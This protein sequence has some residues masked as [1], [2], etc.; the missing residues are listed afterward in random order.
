MRSEEE[1][2]QYIR[3]LRINRKLA[4]IQGKE[5]MAREYKNQ[6]NL[7]RWVKEDTEYIHQKGDE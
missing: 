1:L 6:I 5:R 2:Q 3:G 7:L 4:K